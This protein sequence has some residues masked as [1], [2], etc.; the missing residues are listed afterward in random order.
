VTS[1]TALVI[2]LVVSIVLGWPV[3][4]TIVFALLLVVALVAELGA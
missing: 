2:A 3:W 4:S 1:E